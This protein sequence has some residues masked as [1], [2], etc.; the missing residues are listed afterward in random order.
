MYLISYPIYM[1]YS[2]YLKNT[3]IL[4]S[5]YLPD[6]YVWNNHRYKEIFFIS[7]GITH[8][9]VINDLLYTPIAS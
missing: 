1:I 6:L 8:G 2:K 3:Y 7:M 5:S 4:L 9:S